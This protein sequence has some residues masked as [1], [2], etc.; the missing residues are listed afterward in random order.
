MQKGI[1]L[2]D[3]ARK[4]NM[5]ISTVSKSL[6][7]DNSISPLTKGR[8][9]ELAKQWGYVPNEA[10]R[11]FKLNKTL[12]IGVILPDLLDQFFVHAING[13]EEIADHENYNIILNQTHE[14]VAKEENIANGMIKNRVDGVIVAVT[15]NTVDM[16][17]L[18]KFKYVGIPVM[19]IVREPKQ[20]SF[21]CV[22][23]NNQEG[24]F[25]ATNFLIGKGHNRVAHIM[26]PVTLQISHFRLEG[27]KE[28]LQ[29][30]KIPLDK[31]LIKVVD[32]SK[33]ETERAMKELL[34]LPTPPTAI[35][36]FKNYITLDAI[37]YLK[38]KYP[39][40]LDTID[41]T[42]FGNLS[43]FDYIEKKPVASI[44]ENFYEVGK[45]AAILLFQMIN[46]ENQCPDQNPKNIEIPCELIVH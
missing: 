24:A 46:E 18:E 35:F 20:H 2:K 11:N 45:Q 14:D 40:R 36:T 7:S 43:L 42:D 10:A 30:Y 9:K 38:R 34:T 23:I 5:S 12:T 8:V 44:Q 6:N 37:G 25:K 17:F 28:A 21:N 32:F 3:I 31:N 16:A 27:Y 4:L 22:S 29:K 26:G 19:C 13:V 15:K 39:E 41:F 33:E 1:T